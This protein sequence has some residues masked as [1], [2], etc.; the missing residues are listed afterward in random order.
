[1]KRALIVDDTKNIR[2]LLSTCLEVNGYDCIAVNNGS[3]ALEVLKNEE[4]DLIFLDIKMPEISGTEVLKRIRELGLNTPVVIMTAFATV[5]NAVDC[6]RMGA[7]AYL[8]KPF[9]SDKVKGVL[10]EITDCSSGQIIYPNCTHNAARELIKSNNLDGAYDILKK[11]LAKDAVCSETYQLIGTI[12][13]LKGEIE[14]AKKFYLI[15]D[16]FK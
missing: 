13:E 1:M 6:T 2:V 9:T 10:K 8:Q 4:I 7:V 15:A 5:K 14:Q 12:Y 11:L 16:Q 3:A